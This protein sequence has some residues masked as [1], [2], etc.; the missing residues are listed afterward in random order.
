[1]PKITVEHLIVIKMRIKKVRKDLLS[2]LADLKATEDL[3]DEFI[4]KDS[5]K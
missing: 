1:M 3:L 4:S 5:E 2:G